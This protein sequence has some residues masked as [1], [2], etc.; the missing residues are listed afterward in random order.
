MQFTHPVIFYLVCLVGLPLMLGIALWSRWQY[1]KDLKAFGE[2]KLVQ[3][4]TGHLSQSRRLLRNLFLMAGIFLLGLAL[5]GPQYGVKMVEVKRQGVDILIGL[6]VSRSMLAEDVQPN[7]LKRAQEEL[8]SLVDELHGDRVGV[9]AFAGSCQM[10]CPLTTDYSAA[11][12]FLRYV[13]PD[14]VPILGTDIGQAIAT[15]MENFPAG[16]EGFRVLVLLTDG[17]DHELRVKDLLPAAKAAGIKILTIGFGTAQGE[18]IP[19]RDGNGSVTG[20]VKDSDGKSVM[21]HLDEAGLKQM[22]EAT[23]GA[24]WPAYQGSLEA[25]ALA[26]AIGQMQRRD[27][28][29]G[30]YGAY[31]DRYQFVLVPGLLFLILGLLL[32]ERRKSWLLI[33]PLA[34]LLSQAAIAGVAEDINQGNR[35]YN[36]GKMEQA[37]QVYQDAQIK[38][39]EA[40]AV[41]Y[42]LGNTLQQMKKNE[43]AEKVY[44]KVFKSKSQKIKAMTY[45][46]LGNN[47]VAQQK[48]SEAAKAYKEALH[49]KPRDEDTVYNLAQLTALMKNPP[50][51]KPDQKKQDKNQQDQKDQQQKQ[52]Q[53]SSEQSEKEQPKQSGQNQDKSGQDKNQKGQAQNPK[54][55]DDRGESKA[56]KD[57]PEP[58]SPQGG[59]V[60]RY[61]DMSKE[62]AENILNAVKESEQQTQQDLMR[63]YRQQ[64]G[65]RGKKDW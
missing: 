1:Q 29:S 15:A 36:K 7:R 49:L 56:G 12:M 28:S 46:N 40:P 24:Y 61:S 30:Q 35:L 8:S 58:S 26:D 2:P 9:M 51:T 23:G 43:E 41:N 21:S 39:P 57:Q 3:K 11:K 6:D 18:P 14:S 60:S 64:S 37:Q 5:S 62:E 38:A 42:N 19:I 27:I 13:S 16:G 32:P 22:A 4:L 10:V 54:G 34:L 44:Q 25:K 53:Q 33:L 52:N 63:K 47:Y 59:S 20:Y 45:Y 48:Y 65:G 31:E 17:E 55:P 50:Q